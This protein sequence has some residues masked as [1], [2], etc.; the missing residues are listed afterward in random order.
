M[1]RPRAALAA[2]LLLLVA[3]AAGTR[4]ASAHEG[5]GVL[6]LESQQVASDGTAAYQVRVTWE[7]DGHAAIDSTV[8]ATP[9]ASD[10]SQGVP[11]VLQ[12]VDQDGR[13]AGSLTFD[14]RGTWT[15]R[16]TSV[17][18]AATAEVVEEVAIVPGTTTVPPEDTS[19]TSTTGP[20][21]TA[22]IGDTATRSLD[23]GHDVEAAYN[24][25]STIMVITVGVVLL[26]LVGIVVGFARSNRRLRDD[27]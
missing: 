6:T 25:S 15:V 10:D 3:G 13:Y 23:D 7:N 14:D 18:P 24:Q 26:L 19:T 2:L 20:S 21:A 17:T 16:F 5:E 22:E 27:P 1:N 11:V 8:T 12:A 4:S 9:I